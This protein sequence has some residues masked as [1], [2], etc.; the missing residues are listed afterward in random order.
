MAWAKNGTPDT[1]GSAGDVLTI[2][3]L[4]ATK[5]NMFMTHILP[6][7]TTDVHLEIDDDTTA[8][9]A[10][11]TN[12]NGGT[13]STQVS[14]STLEID[15]NVT[16][17]VFWINYMMNIATE[18]KLGIMFEIRQSTAGAGAAPNRQEKAIKWTNTLVQFTKYEHTNDE[19]GDFD[20]SSNLSALGTD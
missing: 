11:R 14:Q 20:T 15:N 6:T 1:L 16:T 18:E 2:S 12:Y 3:D 10:S 9:Y 19:A 8:T 17:P 4:T 5:F 13:D 7:G